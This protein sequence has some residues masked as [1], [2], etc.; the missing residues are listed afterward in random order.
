MTESLL[1]FIH[2]SDTHISYDPTYSAN[3]APHTSFAGA[4]ALVREINALPFTPDFILHTG[5]VVYDPDEAAYPSAHALLSTLRAP[6]YY[7][8]GNHD[9]ADALQRIMLGATD[10]KSPFDYEFEVNG[11]QVVCLD[12]NRP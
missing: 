6:V 8:A 12:S 11:V 3:D 2:I 7:L 9:D 1:R 4:Q 10:P 5:D